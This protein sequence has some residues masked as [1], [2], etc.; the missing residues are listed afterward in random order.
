MMDIPPSTV[1][2]VTTKGYLGL[3]SRFSNKSA[4][5]TN[6]TDGDV[7]SVGT[8]RRRRMTDEQAGRKRKFVETLAKYLAGPN[9]VRMGIFLEMGRPEAK[10]WA[11]IRG[12]SPLMGY[13]TVKEAASQLLKWLGMGE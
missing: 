13:P 1:L 8:K 10:L 4:V 3:Q 6:C 11:E 7:G 5:V 2:V 12:W 9:Q